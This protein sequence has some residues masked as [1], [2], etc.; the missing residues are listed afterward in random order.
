MQVF[1]LAYAFTTVIVAVLANADLDEFN[2]D[3]TSGKSFGPSDWDQVRC[4]DL[5][6][7]RGWPD[8]WE[9]AIDWEL[10]ENSW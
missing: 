5:Q 4:N 1:L 7:C 8:A 10:K 3:T 2:Y 9:M 6:T